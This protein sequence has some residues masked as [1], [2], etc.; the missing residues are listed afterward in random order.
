[1]KPIRNWRRRL[2]PMPAAP[3]SG[4]RSRGQGSPRAARLLGTAS[5]SHHRAGR[6]PGRIGKGADR[7][8]SALGRRLRERQGRLLLGTRARALRL[9]NGEVTGI[10]AHRDGAD[11]AV[12]ARAVVIADGGFPG[13]AELFRRYIGPRPDRVLMRHAG[14][15]IGDGLKMAAEAGAALIGLDRFY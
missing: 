13:N 2:R 7:L 9:K 10:D 5:R 1:M 14:T 11:L 15:A 12:D 4:W 3:S 6:W 8:L